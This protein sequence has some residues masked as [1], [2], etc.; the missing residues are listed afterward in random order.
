M[1]IAICFFGF[2]REVEVCYLNIFSHLI[3]GYEQADIYAHLWWDDSLGG[4]LYHEKSPHVKKELINKTY[5]KNEDQ[6]F[7]NIY[8]PKAIQVEKPMEIEDFDFSKYKEAKEKKSP[9]PL[10]DFGIF[11]TTLEAVKYLGGKYRP[12][13]VFFNE[14][15]QWKSKRNNLL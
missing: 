6:I 3:R 5:R 13:K 15:S 4:K 1:K 8:L 10:S 9:N 12:D 7:K 14:Y 11:G 2:P